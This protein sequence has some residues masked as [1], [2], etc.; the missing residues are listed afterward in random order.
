MRFENGV[1]LTVK[2]TKF[3]DDEVL[4]R[5]NIG[6]GLLD[7]PKDRQSLAWFGSAFIEG[8]L[9]QITNE[10]M[11]QVL[12]SKVYGARFGIGDDAFVLS[13]STRTDDLPTQMQVLAAYVA[14][15]G[16][17]AEAFERLK[18]AGKTI[19]DQAEVHRPGRAQ[20]R[21]RRPAAL[22]RP[23]LHLPEPRGDRQGRARRPQ[24][25]DRPAP[26]QRPDRGGDRRR[27]HRREGHRGGR[28]APSA[29]C[30]R[31]TPSSRSPASQKQIAF[32]A[33]DRR[34]RSC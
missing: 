10:D 29:P 32:P 33:A 19:H 15:P 8:G 31:A 20:P 23:P 4:V 11:E 30:R 22:R 28:R 9:K 25:A 2:P 5:V 7:L 26:R 16:W 24:G 3:R 17:R 6:D 1:R 13:G 18:G 21:P 34:S 27:H 14:E 12:A